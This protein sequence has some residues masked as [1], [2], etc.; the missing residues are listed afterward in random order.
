L[1]SPPHPTIFSLTPFFYYLDPA[2]GKAAGFGG[3]IIHGLATYG[4]AARALIATVGDH[5]PKSLKM[6]SAKFSSPVKPGDQLETQA[7]EVGPVGPDGGTLELSFV[8]KN[9][10][11][12]AV[13]FLFPS[14]F[15]SFAH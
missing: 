15:L 9:L 8:T 13:C 11:S 4:F 1:A 2:I 14:F 5:D 12:G 6:I 10:S 3:V 7:W